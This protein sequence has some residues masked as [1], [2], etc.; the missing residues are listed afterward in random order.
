MSRRLDVLL[1]LKAL[2]EASVPEAEVLGLDGE[3]APP[4]RAPV[5]GRIIIRSGDPGEPEIDLS[6]LAYNWTHRIPVEIITPRLV[7][8]TAEEVLD[9][10]MTRIGDALVVDRN[11]SGLCDWLDVSAP[12][13]EDIWTEGAEPPRAAEL[14]ITAIYVT[15]SPLS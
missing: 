13:T 3:E 15:A 1:A 14:T 4:G 12:A 11:L 9:S 6:P 7:D 8:L 5:G 10:V 2:I